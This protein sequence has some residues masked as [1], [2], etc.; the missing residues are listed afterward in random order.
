MKELAMDDFLE[1][2]FAIVVQLGLG[3]VIMLWQ[4]RKQAGGN[5]KVSAMTRDDSQPKGTELF[6]A[7]GKHAAR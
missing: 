2:L 3:Y 6:C 5:R 4:S 1:P 7:K